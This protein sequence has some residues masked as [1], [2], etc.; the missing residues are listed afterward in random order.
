MAAARGIWNFE[1]IF[2]SKCQIFKLKNIIMI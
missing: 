2:K 1:N